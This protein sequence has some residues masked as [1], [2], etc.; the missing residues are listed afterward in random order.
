MATIK[1]LNGHSLSDE[2][3][4]TQL[5]TKITQPSTI[6]VGQTIVAKVVDDN[7]VPTE[8]GASDLADGGLPS[9]MEED[10]GKI[11]SIVNGDATWTTTLDGELDFTGD[12]VFNGNVNFTG[13]PVMSRSDDASLYFA[14]NP[15]TGVRM[16]FGI[17]DDGLTHGIYSHAQSCWMI[18]NDNQSQYTKMN[19]LHITTGT[20]VSGTDDNNASFI[21][22]DRAGNHMV[23]DPNEIISKSN[24]TTPTVLNLNTDGGR[25]CVRGGDIYGVTQ[26][27]NNTTGTT[28]TVTLSQSAANFTYLKIY[29]RYSDGVIGGYMV[30]YSPNGKSVD[31]SACIAQSD[32]NGG[33]TRTR[34]KI[35]GTSISQSAN[36]SNNINGSSMA[37]VHYI[38]RVEGYK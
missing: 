4:R 9:Y 37:N 30:V 29:T 13:Q 38:V 34:L 17:R 25:V 36:Y 33:M 3:A 19:R 11:L 27:Y 15:D 5:D 23:F 1:S 10:N 21:I 24:G 2:Y 6:N 18:Y 7:G 35:S 26:L 8:W 28:G 12:V 16:S 22:G 31:V 20:D 32:G 14:E